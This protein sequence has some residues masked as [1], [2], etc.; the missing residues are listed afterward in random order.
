MIGNKEKFVSSN[1]VREVKVGNDQE[2]A[3]LK[4]ASHSKKQA[5]KTKLTI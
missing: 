4:R 5:E 1:T 2:K 3:Q